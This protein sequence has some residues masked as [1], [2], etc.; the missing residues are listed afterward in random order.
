MKMRDFEP[1]VCKCC[2]YKQSDPETVTY[3]LDL[4]PGKDAHDIPYT[5]G[6]CLDNQDRAET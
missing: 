4:N 2:G 1:L 3:F 5:C 6:A